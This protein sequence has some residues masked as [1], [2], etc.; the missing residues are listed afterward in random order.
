MDVAL[1]LDPVTLEAGTS[2]SVFAIGSLEGGTLQV[3][4][5]VDAVYQ[6]VEESPA[7]SPA[8]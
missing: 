4:A 2:V 5:A 1:Q 8:M 7:A 6:M 3:L